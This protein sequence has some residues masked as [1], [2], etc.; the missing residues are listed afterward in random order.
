VLASNAGGVNVLRYGNA[1]AQCLGLEVVLADGKIW[2]GLS[3]LRKDNTGY[4]LRDLM[5]GSEGT[6]GVITAAALKLVP[7]PT[8]Y[9]TALLSVPSPGAALELLTLAG[10][11]LGETISAFELIARQGLEFLS[12]TGLA[13]TA[14]FAKTPDWMVLIEIGLPEG[15][16]PD[17][18]M[19]KLFGAAFEAELVSDGVIAKSEAQRAALWQ[20]RENIPEANR[21]IGPV[22]SHDLS[23]P[24]SEIPAFIEAGTRAVAKL[25]DFRIN[26]FGHIGDGNLHFNVFAPKGRH[27]KEFA[28]QAADIRRMLYDLT[29]SFGGS[30]SAEHGIGRMKTAELQRYGDPQKL[31]MMRAIKSALDPDGILNPG[32]VLG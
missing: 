20:I 26:C 31:M 21:L 4:D 27:K 29:D 9:C 1:R 19:E 13:F 10:R 8:G 12:E 2:H 28:S 24:L 3:R 5:I 15:A 18:A 11:H 16:A 30:F 7:A 32:V 22:S 6:L 14:P 17:A 23:I 25:G